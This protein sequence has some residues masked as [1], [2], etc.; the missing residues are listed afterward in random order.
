MKIP[1]D[2]MCPCLPQIAKIQLQP[3]MGRWY[4]TP[5]SHAEHA[6]RSCVCSGH[7]I[8]A[9]TGPRRPKGQNNPLPFNNNLGG[10]MS[11]QIYQSCVL[12]PV[13][14]IS[15]PFDR[16]HTPFRPILTQSKASTMIRTA[17]CHRRTARTDHERNI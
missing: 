6:H 7:G 14:H 1:A 5:A 2:G 17:I 16:N 3:C 4:D 11:P 12:P 8:G 15:P 9:I 13:D 10:Y